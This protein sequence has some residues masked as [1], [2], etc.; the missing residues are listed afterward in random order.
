MPGP[1]PD[2]T[3]PFTARGEG[4]PF[5]PRRPRSPQGAALFWF[6]EKRMAPPTL[7]YGG[8]DR[9]RTRRPSCGSGFTTSA[10]SSS[11]W[12]SRRTRTSHSFET[13]TTR[14]FR[15]CVRPC[16]A[17]LGGAAVR[18]GAARVARDVR[19]RVV[20]D[21]APADLER[22]PPGGAA[23]RAPRLSALHRSRPVGR[24]GRPSSSRGGSGTRVRRRA[25]GLAVLVG[26]ALG[27]HVRNRAWRTAKLWADVTAKSPGTA[28]AWM[29]YGTALMARG[30]YA[31]ARECYERAAPLTPNYWTLEINRG[32]VE[33]PVGR[34]AEA[35]A[36]FKRAVEL[37][38]RSTRRAL[39]LR[40]LARLRRPRARGPRAPR[41]R[42]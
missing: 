6:V 16:R 33:E 26:L 15:G 5:A 11:R 1:E 27:T 25:F 14:A 21:R 7:N 4:R 24:L 38:P 13:G 32:I 30:A 19:T 40:A 3:R 17:R 29:N 37:G 18:E 8:G 2:G 9:S 12:A 39:L 42:P 28:A 22:D 36:H 20:R 31:Q 23:E 35:E 41:E 34:T 10:F